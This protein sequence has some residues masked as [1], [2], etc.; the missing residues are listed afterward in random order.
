[1]LF[2]VRVW[3]LI[4]LIEHQALLK[5]KEIESSVGLIS[6]LIG[7][8][9]TRPDRGRPTLNGWWAPDVQRQINRGEGPGH[10]VRG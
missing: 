10:S 1:M 2:Q 7:P 5:Y 4:V 9:I 8:L 6:F 3:L